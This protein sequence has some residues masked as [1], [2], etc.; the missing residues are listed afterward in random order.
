MLVIREKDDDATLRRLQDECRAY[1]PARHAGP[2]LQCCLILHETATWWLLLREGLS[3]WVSER[4]DVTATT[5]E[6]LMAKN[7]LVHLPSGKQRTAPVYL[8]LDRRPIGYDSEEKVHLVIFGSGP[9]AEAFA[10]NTAMIAHFPNYCR[11][12][13]LRTRI[14]IIDPNVTALR[15]RMMQRYGQLFDHSFH[16]TLDLEEREPQCVLHRPKYDG[17]RKDFVDIEWEFVKGSSAG[18]AVRQKMAEW[19]A[20]S[21]QQLTIVVCGENRVENTEAAYSLPMETYDNQVQVLC[22]APSEGLP[23]TIGGEK[24]IRPFDESIAHPETLEKLKRVA[25]GVNYVY[26]HTYSLAPGETITA[27]AEIDEEEM[28]SQWDRLRSFTKENSNLFHAMSLGTKLHSMGLEIDDWDR[29]Y[30]LSHREIEILAQV[31]HN[32]WSVEE[33][34]LGYRPVTDQEQQSVENN[35]ALKHQLRTRKIHYGLRA[36][37]DLR[38]DATGKN[39]NTYDLAL[40][41]GIPLI[42]KT[43]TTD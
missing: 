2:R 7:I 4:A 36:Y 21:R 26:N 42:M 43:C 33:L 19:S 28:Q 32:R 24:S 29:Y 9:M 5:M 16:R 20:D 14:T 39:V 3:E 10:F 31:E 11:D 35:I 38:A 40:V 23:A 25:M 6:D 37:D 27:P 15:L 1:D 12:S 30:A 17:R 13:R 18:E 41:Q 8:P 34:I 22:L